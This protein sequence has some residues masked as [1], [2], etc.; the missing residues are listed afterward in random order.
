M[1]SFCEETARLKGLKGRLRIKP[2]GIEDG[3]TPKP[4]GNRASRRHR[5]KIKSRVSVED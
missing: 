1:L 2:S 4:G 5:G 3:A